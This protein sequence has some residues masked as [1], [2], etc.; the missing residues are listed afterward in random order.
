MAAIEAGRPAKEQDRAE[1]HRRIAE[2]RDRD[3]AT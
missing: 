2:G 1:H 3:P